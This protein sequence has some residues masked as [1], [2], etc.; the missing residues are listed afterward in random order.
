[1]RT[2]A[3]T[4]VVDPAARFTLS[5]R[6]EVDA[7]TAVT[8]ALADYLVSL[9]GTDPLGVPVRLKR[10]FADQPEQEAG[11][12]E[13][14]SATIT[15]PPPPI[16]DAADLSP[17]VT[18][19]DR[20]PLP[21]GRWLVK[22][23]AE[24]VAELK[25]DCWCTQEEERV[26]VAA[27]VEDALHPVEWMHGFRLR[28][29]YYAGQVVTYLPKSVQYLDTEAQTRYR[30]AQFMLEARVNVVRF[31]AFPQARPRAVVEMES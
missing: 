5:A 15:V 21:D 25:L 9:S 1:M 30:L 28:V 18:A 27:L 4:L 8:Q 22:T 16:Y 14:P 3:A 19:A 11:L 17:R 12:A 23:G 31:A 7:R 26:Q 13:Y 20:L 29:P 10:V 24:L 6:R 2:P